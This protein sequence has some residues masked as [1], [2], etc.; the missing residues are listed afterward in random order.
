MEL[1]VES[2]HRSSI[3]L[4]AKIGNSFPERDSEPL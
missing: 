2:G 4:M 1:G 3:L